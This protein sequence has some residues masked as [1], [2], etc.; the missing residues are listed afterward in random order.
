MKYAI[1]LPGQ[2]L[3]RHDRAVLHELVVRFL[4][5][6]LFD[7]DS[8]EDLHRALADLRRARMDRGAAVMF[9]G[10]RADAMVAEQQRGRHPDQAAADDEDGDFAIGHQ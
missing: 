1:S 10:E 9:D 2:R 7:A 5:H 4:P 3:D 6:D 8:P